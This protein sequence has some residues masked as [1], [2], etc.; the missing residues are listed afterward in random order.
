MNI[1]TTKPTKEVAATEIISSWSDQHHREADAE[2]HQIHH[3]AG[4]HPEKIEFTA[5]NEPFHHNKFK[6]LSG[7]I[8]L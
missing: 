8:E 5:S 4:H 1:P 6:V 2:L 7:K 3:A